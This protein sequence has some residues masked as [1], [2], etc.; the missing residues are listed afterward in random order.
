MADKRASPVHPSHQ[1][2]RRRLSF[3]IAGIDSDASV[4]RTIR[5]PIL[6]TAGTRPKDI[7]EIKREDV[8]AWLKSLDFK[9]WS[10]VSHFRSARAFFGRAVRDEWIRDN[11]MAGL[12][13]PRVQKDDVSVIS[14]KDAV[15]LFRANKSHP[16]V[17]RLALE[18]FG[19]L[20]AS[21]CR[22]LKFEDIRWEE[23]GIILPASAHKSG[24]RHYMEGQPANLWEWLLLWKDV[25]EAWSWKGL[26]LMHEKS[27]AYLR[28]GLKLPN[29][30]LRR[31]FASYHIAMH[32]DAAKTAILMQHTNQ[33]ML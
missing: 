13:A 18:A 8:R 26:Q 7:S 11:P 19:G 23:H 28:A 31:S 5:Q 27:K 14:V 15:A 17:A 12:D 21:S 9:G 20:R 3:W 1:Y 16:I 24:K 2:T 32:T 30:V 6:T 33:V 25:P 10:L 29:N 4:I 22:R